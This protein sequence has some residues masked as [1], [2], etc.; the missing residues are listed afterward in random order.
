M[1]WSNY[2]KYLISGDKKGQIIY[3]DNKITFKNRIIA[4]D[5]NCI[6][7]LS[8]SL[9]TLKFLSC[10]DDRTAKIFDFVTAQEEIK[11]E[12]HNSDVKTCHWHPQEAIVATGSKD[13]QVKLWDPK[14]GRE[15]H[16]L[17]SHNN[18]IN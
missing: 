1:C 2:E 14:S 13:N 5:Q 8:F 12:G 15:I 17:Q 10:S 16:T 3:S 18:T 7:D 9:S 6:R 11:F 4:H